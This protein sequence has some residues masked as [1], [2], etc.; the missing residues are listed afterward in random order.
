MITWI[1]SS[2]DC[3]RLLEAAAQCFANNIFSQQEPCPTLKHGFYYKM[4]WLINDETGTNTSSTNPSVVPPAQKLPGKNNTCHNIPQ[5]SFGFIYSCNAYVGMQLCCTPASG[6]QK[7][8][9]KETKPPG[10]RWAIRW[11]IS[12]GMELWSVPLGTQRRVE[13]EIWRVLRIKNNDRNEIPL[14]TCCRCYTVRADY[15][16]AI[17]FLLSAWIKSC[18]VTKQHEEG[19]SEVHQM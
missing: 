6:I 11:Q 4:W 19:G 5:I 10:S 12:R 18:C 3:F 14:T 17:I 2:S 13:R 15:M 16:E 8:D 9:N 7:E 1:I